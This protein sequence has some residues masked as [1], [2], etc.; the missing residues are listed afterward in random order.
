MSVRLTIC[1]FVILT[2]IFPI[3]FQFEEFGLLRSFKRKIEVDKQANNTETTTS[4]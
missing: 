3:T 4:K 2:Y 1:L